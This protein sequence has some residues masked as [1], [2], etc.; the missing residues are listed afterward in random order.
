MDLTPA[1]E[2]GPFGLAWAFP[3]APYQIEGIARLAAGSLLLADEMGLGKTIQAIGGLRVVLREGPRRTALI[4]TPASLLLQWRAELRRWAPELRPSTA[5]GTAAQRRAAWSADADVYLVSYESLVADITA[6]YPGAPG[7]RDWAV[8]VADEAQRVKNPRTDS[9]RAL[10]RLTRERSWALTGTPLENR[11]DDVIS[12]LDFVAPGR[13]D[14]RAMM[15]GFRALRAEFL[16]RRRRADVLPK[17]PRKMRFCISQPLQP[18]QRAAYDVAEREGIVWLRS[19]GAAVRVSHVLELILRLKQIC[20]AHPETGE[21]SKLDDLAQRVAGIVAGG[22]KILLFSQF[23]AAPFG[24]MAA[25]ERL[26]QFRPLLVVGGQDAAARDEA[27][28]LFAGDP[29]RRL[30]ILSLR[31][32]GVGLNLTAATVVVLLDQW[33]TPAAAAQAEDRAHRIGQGRTVQV[34]SY[35]CPD[36]IETRIA[37]I[38]ARK[39]ALF[40][41]FVDGVNTADLDR[42]RL[43]DLLEAVG[44]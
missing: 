30:L 31:A 38:I 6:R 27:V 25:A 42:L 15:V 26:R 23:V 40:D 2:P 19:L 18:D 32:G 14:R 35:L 33:W 7:R 43:D 36:T 34:F 17:L 10:C 11:L 8:V 39:Q 37:D 13:F 20:N 1:N 21:S 5:R 24:V 22:E 9:K 44:V 16:L 29:E 4:V 41:T 3:L 12:L 28:R